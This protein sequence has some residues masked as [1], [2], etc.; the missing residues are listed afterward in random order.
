MKIYKLSE[1][2]TAIFSG[3]TP[4]SANSYYW[5]GSFNWLSSGETRNQFIHQTER[6]IT[7][8]GIDNSSTRL[9]KTNDVV[10]ASAGQGHTR[11]QASFL[12]VDTYIN[13]SLIAVRAKRE[14]V[15][16]K[17][18]F[19]LLSTKYEKLRSISDSASTRGSITTKLLGDLEFAIESLNKQQHIVDTTLSLQ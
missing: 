14:L 3:G 5:N 19:Y 4:S 8:A 17:Y 15:L 10:I 12:C 1:I 6:T 11:G 16:P 2:T 18:L 13:Q 7:Q 9:A